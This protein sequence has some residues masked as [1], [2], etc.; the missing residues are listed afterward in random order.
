ML[1]MNETMTTQQ[2]SLVAILIIMGNIETEG[3]G[4]VSSIVRTCYTHV[5]H[6]SRTDDMDLAKIPRPTRRVLV[7]KLLL[8]STLLQRHGKIF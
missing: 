1:V 5:S 2:I 6:Q 7:T 8:E 4:T 3:T